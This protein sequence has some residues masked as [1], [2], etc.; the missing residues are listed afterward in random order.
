M[1][2]PLLPFRFHFYINLIVLK[3]RKF[4]ISGIVPAATVAELEDMIRSQN[5]LMDKLSNECHVLTQKLE[6]ASNRHK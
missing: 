4:L 5:Q 2:F 6:D 3:I 1:L